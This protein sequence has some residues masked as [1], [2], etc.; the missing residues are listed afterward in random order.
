[1][2]YLHKNGIMH[3]D[4]KLENIMQDSKGTLK[5]IDFGLAT[6]D[7]QRLTKCGTPGYIAPEVF[8]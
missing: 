3:R 7:D 6:Y 8:T 4:I 5:L 1:M 2:H